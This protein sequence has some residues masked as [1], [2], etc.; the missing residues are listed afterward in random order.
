[1]PTTGSKTW[2]LDRRTDHRH[3]AGTVARRLEASAATSELAARIE[4]MS[5][6]ANALLEHAESPRRVVSGFR[7]GTA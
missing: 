5:A 6:T 3:R 4:V 7:V 2:R 1:M